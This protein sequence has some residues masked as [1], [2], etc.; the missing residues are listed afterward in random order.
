M[1]SAGANRPAGMKAHEGEGFSGSW[2]AGGAHYG[3]G[4]ALALSDPPEVSHGIVKSQG[5]RR[6]SWVKL[7]GEMKK[8]AKIRS[9]L[10]TLVISFG[11]AKEDRTPDLLNAIQALSQLSYSPTIVPL[12][13][14][15]G[16]GVFSARGKRT[17]EKNSTFSHAASRRP[18]VRSRAHAHCFAQAIFHLKLPGSVCPASGSGRPE[19]FPE[20]PCHID[21]KMN[22]QSPDH[23]A[24]PERSAV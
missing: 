5:I 18:S 1:K 23:P 10:N 21:H 24:A 16:E 12:A 9:Y 7:W 4:G 2:F 20:L 13:V 8:A 15:F 19:A 6:A 22:I 14:A 11:G 17:Q 3:Q